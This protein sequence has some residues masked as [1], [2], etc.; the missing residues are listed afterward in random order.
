MNYVTEELLDDLMMDFYGKDFEKDKYANFKKF[1][2]EQQAEYAIKVRERHR[3]SLSKMANQILEKDAAGCLRGQP[4]RAENKYSRRLFT[5]ITGIKLPKTY[6]ETLPVLNAWLGQERIAAMNAAIAA[7]KEAQDRQRQA[8][9]EEL[10][11]KREA[12]LKPLI[13]ANEPIT[14]PDLLF[15]ANRYNIEVAPRTAG[16]IANKVLKIQKDVASVRNAKTA[17][18]AGDVY[19]KVLD[20]LSPA[21]ITTELT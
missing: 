17:G 6:R 15:L 14:G 11:A 18:K 10:N 12:R 8:E 16:F 5:A 3:A 7:E 19:R 20:A 4:L 21:K 9:Y 13:L 2:S 1:T